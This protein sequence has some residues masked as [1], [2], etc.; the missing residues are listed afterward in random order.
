MAYG[1]CLNLI[2]SRMLQYLGD[3]WDTGMH[4]NELRKETSLV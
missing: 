2:V 3:G 1:V 4:V